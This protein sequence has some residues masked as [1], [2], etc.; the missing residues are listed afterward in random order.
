VVLISD[1]A[2]LFRRLPAAAAG[3][4]LR[5]GAAQG[6][7]A[8]TSKRWST[9]TPGS[10]IKL[11]LIAAAIAVPLNLGLRH[12]GSV[13]DRQVRVSRQVAPDHLDRPAVLRVAGHFG[14]VYVLLFGA[15]GWFGP[16]L[17]EHDIKIIFAVPGIVLAT[18]FVTFPFV[19]RELIPLMQQ[20]GK[21]RGRSGVVLGAPAG[22]PSSASRCRT[23]SGGCSTA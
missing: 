10:A 21:R 18:I 22:R 12:R 8:H 1:R 15:Q 3:H 20:Q 9:A 23:S 13:V 19:A 6:L 4:G 17:Q 16:W 2:E 5:R 7:G 11:T 14:L